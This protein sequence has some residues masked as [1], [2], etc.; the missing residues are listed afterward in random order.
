M[1]STVKRL[2]NPTSQDWGRVRRPEGALGQ[3]EAPWHR[4]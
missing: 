2:M 4:Q 3:H 1:P